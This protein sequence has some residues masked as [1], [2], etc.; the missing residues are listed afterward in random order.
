M[1]VQVCNR[2]FVSFLNEAS[3]EFGGRL[4]APLS[5]KYVRVYLFSDMHTC[6]DV[7]FSRRNRQGIDYFLTQ[8]QKRP[9]DLTGRNAQVENLP[10]SQWPARNGSYDDALWGGARFMEPTPRE[11][12]HWAEFNGRW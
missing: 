11:E 10:R 3:L 9:V 12:V 8:F 6:T 7:D 2:E 1:V 5:V 4:V